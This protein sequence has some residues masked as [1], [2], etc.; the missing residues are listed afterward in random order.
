MSESLMLILLLLTL[1]FSTSDNQNKDSS[2]NKYEFDS[3]KEDSHIRDQN[4]FDYDDAAESDLEDYRRKYFSN[5][6]YL[7]DPPVYNPDDFDES[8]SHED[9]EIY[10]ISAVS[11]KYKCGCTVMVSVGNFHDKCFLRFN[12]VVVRGRIGEGHDGMEC[13][14]K[15][16]K[17]DGEV[18][19]LV[20]EDEEFWVH[21]GDI[22]VYSGTPMI[23]TIG[24]FV[25]II[26]LIIVAYIGS[27]PKEILNRKKYNRIENKYNA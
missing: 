15:I 21:A 14:G 18:R 11:G 9:N 19:V 22:I 13:R 20:S 26:A 5:E 16:P 1:S 23:L 25:I 4:N 2:T 3:K 8:S 24:V 17:I 6:C 7:N 27:I 12:D 10:V